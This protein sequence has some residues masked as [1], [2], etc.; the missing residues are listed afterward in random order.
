MTPSGIE[1]ATFRINSA[2]P[3]PTAL[4]RDPR[5]NLIHFKTL[6]GPPTHSN[7]SQRVPTSYF[8]VSN[9]IEPHL[10]FVI[11]WTHCICSAQCDTTLF[12]AAPRIPVPG[13]FGHIPPFKYETYLMHRSKFKSEVQRFTTMYQRDSENGNFHSCNK[14]KLDTLYTCHYSVVNTG[15]TQWTVPL[16]TFLDTYMLLLWLDS[17]P[18]TCNVICEDTVCVCVCIYIYI[19]IHIYNWSTCSWL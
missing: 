19:Y 12:T 14:L 1:P 16:R 10:L 15:R 2:V 18:Q 11:D 17:I 3:Q 4:P 7:I 5:S 8:L 6:S 13:M 9:Y